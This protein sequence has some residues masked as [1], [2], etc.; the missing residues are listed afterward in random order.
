METFRFYT[1]RSIINEAGAL[2]SIIEIFREQGI[3]RPLIV[4]DAGVESAGLLQRLTRVLDGASMTYDSFT[5]VVADPPEALV[6]FPALVRRV[7]NS[8]YVAILS[9]RSRC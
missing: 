9:K 7:T 8:R 2:A 3:E 1:A 6:H 4:T 5:R